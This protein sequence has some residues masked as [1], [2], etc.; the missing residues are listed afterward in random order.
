MHSDFLSLT[1]CYGARQK[2]KAAS[3]RISY[4][5]GGVAL[6]PNPFVITTFLFPNSPG[7]PGPAP[8]GAWPIGRAA[9]GFATNPK[10]FLL[11]QR[12]PGFPRGQATA[13]YFQT[14]F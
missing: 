6:F 12:L 14:H 5:P 10:G 4:W 9:Q 1:A 7:Q 2:R 3:A 13:L 8:A 11:A